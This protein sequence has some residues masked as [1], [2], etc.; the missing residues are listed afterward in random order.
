MKSIRNFMSEKFGIWEFIDIFPYHWRMYYYEYIK[1]IFY[2]RN[3]RLRKFIPRKWCDTTEMMVD[4]NFEMIKIF[5]EEEY[6][7]GIIDWKENE[8]HRNFAEWLE[9]AYSY[10][11]KVRPE[12]EKSL[13]DSY[14]KSSV[15]FWENFKEV[16]REDGQKYY[17]MIPDGIPYEVK[18]KDVIHFEKTISENDTKILK[19][20]VDNREF[21]WT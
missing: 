14:P 15:K 10:I 2:P 9:K 5:Y 11:T 7:N 20:F 12:L 13:S 16:I 6:V 3:K 8:A 4:I 17:E 1:P 19:E 21:F 18:Y